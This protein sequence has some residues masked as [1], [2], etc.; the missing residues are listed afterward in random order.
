MRVHP[1]TGSSQPKRPSFHA[2]SYTCDM[3]ASVSGLEIVL[4]LAS[5]A[6]VFRFVAGAV[7]IGVRLGARHR[8]P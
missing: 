6:L 5:L 7:A 4:S 1:A 8:R 3:L 2:W